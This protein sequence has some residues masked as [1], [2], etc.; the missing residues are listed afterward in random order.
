MRGFIRSVTGAA[1]AI[2]G[3]L[4]AVQTVAATTIDFNTGFILSSYAGHANIA[5]LASGNC[6]G[7]NSAGCFY[8]DGFAIGI[9]SDPSNPSAHFHRAGPTTDRELAYH[10]DTSGV[11][12]RAVDGSAFALLSMAFS[13]PFDEE[14]NPD[15]GPNDLWEIMGF[16]TAVNPTLGTD[17]S[18]PTRVAYMTVANPT[19]AILTLDASFANVNAIWITY[20]GYHQTPLDGKAYEAH[21]DDIVL[22]AAISPPAV[23]VPLPAAG[24]LLLSASLASGGLLVE[25]R[26]QA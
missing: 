25:R 6:P 5:P 15:S 13:A 10:S 2:M 4:G 24:L 19:N 22:G 23:T 8:E 7:V 26:R 9:V 20:K 14:V 1:A 11:Y 3:S 18:F 16:N 12:I 17:A 21:I